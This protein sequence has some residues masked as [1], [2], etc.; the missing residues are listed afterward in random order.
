MKHENIH[1]ISTKVKEK[2]ESRKRDLEKSRR[3]KAAKKE[4]QHLARKQL[5]QE[6]KE[7]QAKAKKEKMMLQKEMTRI[8]KEMELEH[9]LKKEQIE[10]YMLNIIMFVLLCS[11]KCY[12]SNHWLFRSKLYGCVVKKRKLLSVLIFMPSVQ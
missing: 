2:S 10:K 4:A 6:E 3:E 11:L 1:Y 12:I 7:K 5:L 9:R 8:R